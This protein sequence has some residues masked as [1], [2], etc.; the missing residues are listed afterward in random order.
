MAIDSLPSEH[1]PAL[2]FK[3][4]TFSVPVLFLY[5][6][7][8]A[9]IDQQLQQKIQLA[10]D[11]FKNSPIVFDVQEINKKELN[12]DIAELT[13]ILYKSG[14]LPIGI[15]GGN[16]EQNNKA[17]ELLIPAYSLH[18]N[19]LHEAKSAESAK[20]AKAKVETEAKAL[21]DKNAATLFINQPVRSGQR[22]YSHGD[23]IVTAQV[24]PGAEIMAE[25]NIHVY[26][27][28]KGRVSA[29]VL[30]NTDARIFC[31][32]LEAE[33]VSI[34]GHYKVNE[35]LDVAHYRK[36]PVQIYLQEHTL[37]IDII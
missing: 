14:M 29:G 28:L 20:D 11:F 32:N 22:I 26:N 13:G 10:P 8:L 1:T 35:D 37:I 27:T 3:G 18:H 24:S 25:G 34:A 9:V 17:L 16:K 36:K 31:L 4:S 30:G 7:D 23:L 15:R 5:S 21:P 2:E 33:L 6:N 19:I 12:I